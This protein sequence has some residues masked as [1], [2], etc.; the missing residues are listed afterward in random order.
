M[1]SKSLGELYLEWLSLQVN[2]QHGRTTDKDFS[3]LFRLLNKTEF[4]WN[5]PN[6]DNRVADGLDLRMEFINYVG[7]Q[8]LAADDANAHLTDGASVLEVLIGLSRRLSFEADGTAEGWAWQLIENLGLNLMFN[9][10]TRRKQT[11]VEGVL[12]D[13]VWRHYKPDGQGG[14]FPLIQPKKDQRK[15]ELWYQMSEYI[16]EIA[17]L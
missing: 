16:G 12:A 8:G 14:F 11:F 15:V 4:V 10:M 6:D 17:E 3:D 2:V 1:M 5:V 9:P 7:E 13:L